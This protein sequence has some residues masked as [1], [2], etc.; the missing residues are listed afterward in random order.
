MFQNGKI[1]K[2]YTFDEVRDN[3][4]LKESELKE[5]ELQEPLQ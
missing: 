1:T 4:R 2:T 5:M 3:A